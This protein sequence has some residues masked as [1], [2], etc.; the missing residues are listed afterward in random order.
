MDPTRRI[1]LLTR[2]VFIAMSTCP[3]VWAQPVADPAAPSA[4]RPIVQTAP[5]GVPVVNIAQPNAAG[6]SHNLFQSFSVEARGVVLNNATVGVTAPAP[7]PPSPSPPPPPP[8]P[9]YPPPPPPCGGDNCHEPR[10]G[11]TAPALPRTSAAPALPGAATPNALVPT[12]QSLATGSVLVGS[13][14]ANP[15]LQGVAAQ[16]IV[17]EVTG[18]TAS[19]LAG[20]VEV[21]GNRADLVLANPWGITCNGCGF[22]GVNRATLSSGAP[23]WAGTA[24][25]GFDVAGSS[26]N[27]GAAGL[28]GAGLTGLDLLGG[29]VNVAG[30]VNL[31]DAGATVYVVAGPNQVN[32]AT[33][34]ATAR[35]RGDGHGGNTVNIGSAG[36]LYADRI[37]VL[38]T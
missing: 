9:Y 21:F 25:D 37:F 27:I 31:P 35:P 11:P 4:K 20:Q 5:N 18:G 38:S 13:I 12:V 34:A 22:I 28:N 30:T 32:Y 19:S 29:A 15:L 24:L 17:A 23:V 10:G 36:G 8:P 7:P 2:A 26:V 3:P 14:A 6:T 33:L 1:N 16:R